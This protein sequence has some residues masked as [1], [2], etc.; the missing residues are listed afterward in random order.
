M[1][2]FTNEQEIIR[3]LFKDFLVP[4]N[5]R[6]ISKVISISHV[7][8]FKILKN[9]EKRD[10]AKS[11]RIGRAVIYSLNLENP[12]TRKEIEMI[13]VVEAQNFKRWIEEF[14]DLEK[15]VIFLVLFGSII[16]NEKIAKDIDLLL[17]ADNKKLKN[18]KKTIEELQ[19]YTN[20]K[21]HPL[22]QTL[23]DF[24]EDLSNGNKVTIDIIKTGVVLF[25]Q[26]EYRRVLK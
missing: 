13:L 7:G 8:A 16:R 22:I 6:N 21:I 14:K 9:L 10:I 18:V 25:G 12:I 23:K 19:K 2:K 11:K 24:K 17:V 26:E 3:L 1:E 20:K 4:Y 5:S 15:D